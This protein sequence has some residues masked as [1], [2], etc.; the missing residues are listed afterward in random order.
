MAT[1]IDSQALNFFE[2][3]FHFN[4]VRA[5]EC[6]QQICGPTPLPNRE[7]V[8]VWS[9][10]FGKQNAFQHFAHTHRPQIQSML[11]EPLLGFK[12]VNRI[13]FEITNL[14][15][16]L[17]DIASVFVLVRFRYFSSLLCSLSNAFVFFA[18]RFFFFAST[19]N[20]TIFAVWNICC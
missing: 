12:S 14:S 8:I 18:I 6:L 7:A 11:N 1:P 9:I 20:Y 13:Q 19:T 16:L 15:S 4:G 2:K 17:F 3:V 5:N 10:C